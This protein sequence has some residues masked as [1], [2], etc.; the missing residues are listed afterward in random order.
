MRRGKRIKTEAEWK[1]DTDYVLRLAGLTD[2]DDPEMVAL[3]SLAL[4]RCRLY[5]DCV[6]FVRRQMDLRKSTVSN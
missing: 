6:L 5:D 3:A 4:E 1:R 2:V